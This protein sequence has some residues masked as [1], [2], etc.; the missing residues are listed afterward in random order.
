MPKGIRLNDPTQRQ[1]D[2]VWQIIERAMIEQTT[3]RRLQQECIDACER[4]G[5]PIDSKLLEK[6]A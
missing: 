3:P 6:K 4:A 1:I 5:C 2:V